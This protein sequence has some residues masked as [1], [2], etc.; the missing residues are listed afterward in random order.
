MIYVPTL[1]AHWFN[2]EL[3]LSRLNY[4]SYLRDQVAAPAK[5]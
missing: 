1:F 5:A 3:V 2:G 4:Q